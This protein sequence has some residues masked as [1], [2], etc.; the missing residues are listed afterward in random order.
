MLN[1]MYSHGVGAHKEQKEEKKSKI[2][3]FFLFIVSSDLSQEDIKS[4]LKSQNFQ[5]FFNKTTK[6]IERALDGDDDNINLMENIMEKDQ[7]VDKE[8]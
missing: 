6:M 2:V 8:E 1:E 3:L 5:E 7:I 4:I